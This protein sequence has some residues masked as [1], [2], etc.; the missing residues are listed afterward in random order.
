MAA[1]NSALHEAAIDRP[2]Q[3]PRPQSQA[4]RFV[5]LCIAHLACNL[6]IA[7]LPAICIVEMLRN[8]ACTNHWTMVHFNAGH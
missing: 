3:D 7:Q 6:S 1:K 5:R 8:T 4:D 2:D